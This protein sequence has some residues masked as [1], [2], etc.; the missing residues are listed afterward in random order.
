MSNWDNEWHGPVGA[1][2]GKVEAIAVT[3]VSAIIDLSL[4]TNIYADLQAGRMVLADADG[5]P[6]YYAFTS[7]ATGTIDNTSTTAGSAT[8]CARISDVLPPQRLRPPILT[9][10]E[11]NSSAGAFTNTGACRYLI[12]KTASTGATLRLSVC[13]ED[14]A[15]RTT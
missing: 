12:V 1:R 4:R 10:Q 9:Q 7:E 15:K 5:A 13:S 11:V 3:S 6:V 2:L 14:P 8:A